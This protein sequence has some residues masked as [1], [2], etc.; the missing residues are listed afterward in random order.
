VLAAL[1]MPALSA[2]RDR[3]KSATCVNNG[4][5]ISVALN[6]FLGDHD[7]WYPYANPAGCGFMNWCVGYNPYN[8]YRWHRQLV[9]TCI[10]NRYIAWWAHGKTC[11]L[12]QLSS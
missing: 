6:T 9:L 3:A 2:A 10:D 4:R 5:Q 11:A 8:P 1:L 7:Q 12:N